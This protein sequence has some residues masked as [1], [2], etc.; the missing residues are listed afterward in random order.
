LRGWRKAPKPGSWDSLSDTLRNS[1]NKQIRE[2]ATELAAV[3]GDGR[4]LDGLRQLAMDDKADPG[5]RRSA[6][7][8]LIT[9]HSTNL[10]PVILNL[11]SDRNLARNAVHGLAIFNEPE[12]AQ[13][14]LARYRGFRSNVRSDVISV[15]TSRASYSRALLE[16]VA[17]GKVD[18]RDISAYHVRQIQSFGDANLNQLLA[19]NWGELRNSNEQKKGQMAALRA[20][21][22]P[23]T[24]KGADLKKGRELFLKTCA[25]CH[26]LYGEG[27][28]IAPDLTGSG[29]KDLGY[30]VENIVDP[31]ALVAADYK[32]S[33]VEL[34][35]G[36]ILTGVLVE[37]RERTISVQMLTEKTIIDRND[38]QRIQPSLLS[39]MPE[40]LLEGLRDEEKRDLF[41]YLMTSGQP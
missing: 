37:K 19:E 13:E 30:L 29:R 2:Q 3:F 32:M 31:N 14:I 24:I 23:E 4:A 27:A 1:Q 15:L 40:G 11:L 5:A 20:K 25:T 9:S 12:L 39:L 16:A 7:E 28:S 18:R 21:L 17:V 22:T 6:L 10:L 26:R 36:R 41:A 34:K 33:L 35:D 38:I 8:T